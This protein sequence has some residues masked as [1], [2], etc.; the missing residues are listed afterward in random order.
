MLK[1][2]KRLMGNTVPI[3]LFYDH[4]S[5]ALNFTTDIKVFSF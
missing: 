1:I 5:K 3:F 2:P 4:P